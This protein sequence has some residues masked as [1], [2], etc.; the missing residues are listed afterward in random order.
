[1]FSL[2]L[3]RQTSG[4]AG[5]LAFG[6]LPPVNVTGNWTST[7]ILITTIQGYP[8]TYDFYT[9]QVNSVNIGGKNWR[10]GNYIVC[11]YLHFYVP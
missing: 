4:P 5:Y 10:G 7:P 11:S 8:R 2:A 3:E 1:M 6:G 9:I